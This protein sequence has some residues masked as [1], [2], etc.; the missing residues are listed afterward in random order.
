[1]E[2]AQSPTPASPAPDNPRKRGRTACTRCKTR[3][4]KV[5]L[6]FSVIEPVKTPLTMVVVR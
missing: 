6:L 5:S 2:F 4:Q 1:M 3:K